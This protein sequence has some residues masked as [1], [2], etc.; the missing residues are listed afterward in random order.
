MIEMLQLPFMLQALI[1]CVIMG[2]LLAYLGIHVVSRGIVF[3]DLALGQIS[4]LGVAFAAF[5]GGAI[6][7]ISIT[8]TLLGAFLLSLIHIQDKRLRQEAIIGIIYAV[9]SAVTVLLISKTPHGEADISEVLFGNIL[10]IDTDE[11]ITMGIVFAIL[12][13]LHMVFRRQVAAVTEAFKQ[14]Q[15]RT[16]TQ[17][18]FWNFFF[19]LSIG[20]A[21]VFAVR[22]GGVIPVFSY[23][24][25]PSVCAIL[26]SQR[27]SVVTIL[28]LAFAVLVSL[29][30]LY[31]SYSFDFPAGS[32]IVTVFGIL[33]AGCSVVKLVTRGKPPLG[34]KPE[35]S[36]DMAVESEG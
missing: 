15:P 25:I 11:M 9:S 16:D 20:L 22:A 23:L 1:G 36:L 17:F 24:V 28:A 32:S 10:A 3:V 30:G 27:P 26:I 4:S 34:S 31:F 33:L 8:F 2:L 35:E 13:L 5:I 29:F 6:L 18:R 7:P 12:G 19:Y 14:G 21:I